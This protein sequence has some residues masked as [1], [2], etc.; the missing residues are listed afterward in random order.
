VAIAEADSFRSQGVNIR[1]GVPVIAIAAEVIRTER[2]DVD[3]EEVHF[4]EVRV[5]SAEG[6]AVNDEVEIGVERFVILLV[7]VLVIE[8]RGSIRITITIRKW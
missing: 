8:N 4:L 5:Q 3:V 1:T 2:V 6:S 7:L